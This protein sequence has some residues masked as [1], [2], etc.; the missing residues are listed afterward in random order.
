MWKSSSA[1][2]SSASSSWNFRAPAGH[3]GF[4]PVDDQIERRLPERQST[5]GFAGR[6]VCVVDRTFVNDSDAE[7][8]EPSRR[9]GHVWEPAFGG[10][11]AGGVATAAQPLPASGAHV[12]RGGGV[13]DLVVDDSLKR[14]RRRL[15]GES[16]AEHREV[17]Q[18]LATL[19]PEA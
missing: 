19:E 7:R 4:V 14:P 3:E 18:W 1:G 17:P 9:D 5:P 8:S 10:D 16:I 12:Q 15:R 13:S 2:G 11:G 6:L